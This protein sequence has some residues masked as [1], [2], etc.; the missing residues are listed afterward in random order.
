MVANAVDG[1]LLHVAKTTVERY[2]A[3]WNEPDADRRAGYVARAWA[4]D[5]RYLDP[6]L[7]AEGHEA[8]GQ[9][10]EG[11]HAQFPGCRLRQVGAIDMHH[12]TIRFGW[13]LV[14]AEQSVVV[15]GID[16]GVLAPD[17]RLQSITGFFGDLERDAA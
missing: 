4:E 1:Y 16:V 8:L 5:G 7:Q 13:E 15:A 6:A 10:V 3:M 12:N 17:G 11:V 9:M 2:F 14:D